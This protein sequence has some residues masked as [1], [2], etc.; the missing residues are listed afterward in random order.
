MDNFNFP[1]HFTDAHENE[2]RYKISPP[3]RQRGGYN[4]IPY[5]STPHDF[6]G[7]QFPQPQ[8]PFLM[9]TRGDSI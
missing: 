4:E 5:S 7:A 8:Q 3:Q 9:P 2:F 6:N 1:S